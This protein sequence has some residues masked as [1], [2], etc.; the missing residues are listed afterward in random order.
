VVG[1]RFD[2]RNFTDKAGNSKTAL[3][4]THRACS[5]TLEVRYP[6]VKISIPHSTECN[7]KN[8]E[9]ERRVNDLW[10]NAR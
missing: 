1:V 5:G 9:K 7:E 2:G 4:C 8:D 10:A 3:N 6:F